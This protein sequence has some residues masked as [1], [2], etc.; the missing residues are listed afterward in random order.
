MLPL[1][2]ATPRLLLLAARQDEWVPAATVGGGLILLGL[3]LITSH[4]RSWQAHAIDES[5]DESELRYYRH[6]FRRR[7][8][9]S[10]IILLLGFLVPI[11]DFVI[12][13]KANDASLAA[14]YWLMVL[15]LT[16]WMLLLAMGDLVATRAHSRRTLSRLR[17]LKQKQRELQAEAD[18]LRA[19]AAGRTNGSHPEL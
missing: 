15:A 6:Q 1:L 12:P 18:R 8:Q 14:L 10:G 16:C 19:A 13:W 7:I 3:W 11:G 5:L 9:A 4:W 17:D 2:S